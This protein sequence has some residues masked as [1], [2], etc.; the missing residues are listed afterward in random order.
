MHYDALVRLAI[1]TNIGKSA[2]HD[3]CENVW[4]NRRRPVFE[5]KTLV[6]VVKVLF[7]SVNVG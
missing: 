3:E 1:L 6:E 4:V 2:N 7:D 5:L